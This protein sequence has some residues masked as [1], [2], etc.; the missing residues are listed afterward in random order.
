VVVARRVNSIVMVLHLMNVMRLLLIAS[1]VLVLT[2]IARGQDEEMR[3]SHPITRAE[4]LALPRRDAAPALTLQRALRIA[5]RFTKQ[6][7]I[8]LSSA[9]LFEAKWVSYD[10]TPVTGAW[11]FWWVSTKHSKPDVRIAVSVDGKPK[12]LPLPGA[13]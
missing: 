9:Y 7:K 1:T 5:G 2:T 12:L 13:T 10:T 4:I 8:D 11:H 3:L 6:Q